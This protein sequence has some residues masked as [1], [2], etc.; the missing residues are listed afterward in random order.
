[1]LIFHFNSAMS[2]GPFTH[3]SNA[4]IVYWSRLSLVVDINT[5]RRSVCSLVQ[6]DSMQMHIKYTF[7]AILLLLI[8]ITVLC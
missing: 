1:M 6:F 2:T 5:E 8:L 4:C 3:L 7:R